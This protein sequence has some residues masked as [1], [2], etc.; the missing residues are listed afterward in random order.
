MPF[1]FFSSLHVF[2]APEAVLFFFAVVPVAL[3]DAVL[4]V[5][6]PEVLPEESVFVVPEAVGVPLPVLTER[7][8]VPDVGVVILFV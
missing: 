6:V 5:P 8:V 1:V 4:P 3:F 7:F 2:S